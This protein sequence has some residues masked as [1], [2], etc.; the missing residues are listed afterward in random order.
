MPMVARAG[1][2]GL[3]RAE[4]SFYRPKTVAA[5]DF[6]CLIAHALPLSVRIRPRLVFAVFPALSAMV[7]CWNYGSETSFPQIADGVLSWP[8]K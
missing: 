3:K 7:H 2:S 6:A 4:W 8:R 5:F 1:E